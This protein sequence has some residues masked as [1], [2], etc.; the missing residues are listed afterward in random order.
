MKLIITIT[1]LCFA[2]CSC[3]TNPVTGKRELAVPIKGKF[4]YVDK[5]G[6]SV[7]VGSDGREI[8][9]EGNIQGFAK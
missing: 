9:I 5:N 1:I 2:I 3:V 7:C 4:C 6:N 8:V